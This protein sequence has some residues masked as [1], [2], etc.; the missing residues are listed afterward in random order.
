[1]GRLKRHQT[2]K[3]QKNNISK[4]ELIFSTHIQNQNHIKSTQ[5]KGG[6]DIKKTKNKN[7]NKQS[8]RQ[9]DKTTKTFEKKNTKKQITTDVI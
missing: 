6:Y 1:M 9:L 3:M 5:Q 8:L 2:S 4:A 7:K